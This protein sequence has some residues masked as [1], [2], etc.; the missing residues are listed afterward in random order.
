MAR[1]LVPSRLALEIEYRRL[2]S[3]NKVAALYGTTASTLAKW[4]VERGLILPAPKTRGPRP[5]KDELRFWIPDEDVRALR[6][7]RREHPDATVAELV[8]GLGLRCSV[9]AAHRILRCDRR[10]RCER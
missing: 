1:R 7:A 9:A 3:W 5:R 6:R 10:T 2:G 4:R 8:K